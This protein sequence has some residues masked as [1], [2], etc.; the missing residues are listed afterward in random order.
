MTVH[1]Y[2]TATNTLEKYV[3]AP[4]HTVILPGDL[5]R[6]TDQL[7]NDDD[8]SGNKDDEMTTTMLLF[9]NFYQYKL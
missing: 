8:K 7:I 3:Y 4:I 6:L 5:D 1:Q 9:F 2:C